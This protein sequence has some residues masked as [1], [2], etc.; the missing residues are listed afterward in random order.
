MFVS[1]TQQ[2]Q[3]DPAVLLVIEYDLVEAGGK[4]QVSGATFS[5]GDL[6]GAPLAL[7]KKLPEVLSFLKTM[8][9]G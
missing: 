4:I 5:Y 6:S 7:R 9:S 8:Q 2:Y 3:C 1:E